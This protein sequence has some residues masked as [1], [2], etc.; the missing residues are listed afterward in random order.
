MA[1]PQLWKLF[2]L[3]WTL[4]DFTTILWQAYHALFLLFD[5][6]C[7]KLY[8][9]SGVKLSSGRDSLGQ[10]YI[11]PEE[12]ILKKGADV[13][14]VGRGIL[15]TDNPVQTAIQ[16]KETG[17]KAY[18]ES[19]NSNWIVNWQQMIVETICRNYECS[20]YISGKRCYW[21]IKMC[22]LNWLIYFLVF[23]ATL[24]NISAILCWPV[25]EVEEAGVP[26]ENHQTWASN[27]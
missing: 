11:T 16:Y 5:C 26:G 1:V 27:W 24:R 17:Y 14:I 6:L 20:Y 21:R 13:I 18:E 8:Y 22:K 15:A 25:L 3:K 7:K 23:N 12:A 19:L 9:F 10:Q 4:S 2:L